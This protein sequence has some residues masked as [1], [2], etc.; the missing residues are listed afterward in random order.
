LW[1]VVDDQNLARIAAI[2]N[3]VTLVLKAPDWAQK[4]PNTPCGPIAEDSLDDFASFMQALVA[5]YGQPPYNVKYWEIGNEPSV[6]H[7]HAPA[8]DGYGCWG[9]AG[10]PFFGGEYYGE[11]LKYIYP[12]MKE[13]DPEA[14]VLVGGLLLNCN[15]EIYS[16][17]GPTLFL[18]GIL[19][20]EGGDHF[21]GVAFHAYDYYGLELGIYGNSNWDSFSFTTGPILIPKI[22]YI[23]DRLDAYGYGDRYLVNTE[24]AML[25]GSQEGGDPECM[26]AD[27]YN[28]QAAYLLESYV[29]GLAHELPI[30]IWYSFHEQWEN[31]GL[32]DSN[33]NPKPAFVA[34]QWANNRLGDVTYI[35]E[36]KP[37]D[38]G[39]RQ[40]VLGYKFRRGTREIWVLW[41]KDGRVK[42]FVP[43]QTPLYVLDMYGKSK[44]FVDRVRIEIMPQYIEFEI[45]P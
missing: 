27:Y 14:Q 5:R 30:N 8:G 20:N 44:P 12:A 10:D 15:P 40:Q 31:A 13:T 6:D 9:E 19:E 45:A 22:E 37:A 43:F 41:S 25:C 17:C 28:T 4:Y 11:M 7:N 21:D 23:Q 34:L 42:H 36:I 18:D 24:H 32:L 38:V 16:N 26:T 3:L 33:Q 1:E 35:G 2:G 29:V 39:G